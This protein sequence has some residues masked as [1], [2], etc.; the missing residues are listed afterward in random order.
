MSYIIKTAAITQ[1]SA[2][3][4]FNSDNLNL[5]GKVL[6]LENANNGFKGA[7]SM[8]TPFAVAYASSPYNGFAG[9]AL[10]A[11]NDRLDTLKE[12]AYRFHSVFD[13]FFSDSKHALAQC[14]CGDEGLSVSALVGYENKLVAVKMGDACVL[15][16]T[17]GELINMGSAQ[18]NENQSYACE[19]IDTVTDGDLFVLCPA[20]A[21]TAMTTGEIIIALNAADGNEKKAVQMLA[22]KFAKRNPAA[23]DTFAVIR[24]VRQDAPVAAAPVETFAQPAPTPVYTEP[25]VEV[26]QNEPVADNNVYEPEHADYAQPV[27][28]NKGKTA[29]LWVG[30]C[31][32]LVL[33]MIITGFAAYKIAFARNH[34][35]VEAGVVIAGSDAQ[36][37]I[38]VD[39]ATQPAA[40]EAA[41]EE[42]T[43]EPTAEEATEEPTEE[44]TEAADDYEEDDYY[45]D[46]ASDDDYYDDDDDYYEDDYEDNGTVETVPRPTEAP[47]T[48]PPA[49]EPDDNTGD[50]Y[51]EPDY[52]FDDNS[53]GLIE[54]PTDNTFTP[55]A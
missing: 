39:T 14:N 46:D 54:A 7:G 4:E 13:G 23:A 44:T 40:T 3:G 52:G 41:T 11:L 27:Q 34:G 37:D 32:A 38:D 50:D 9:A 42:A 29:L 45:G 17:D 16:Y 18:E 25:P 1:K 12:D 21:L 26:Q 20:A 24:I 53:G 48:N 10:T 22:A 49:E 2:N 43:E 51:E 30:L 6:S 47:A 31:A 36:Y 28:V 19:E 55:E 15:R 8:R 35:D 5:N 33:L